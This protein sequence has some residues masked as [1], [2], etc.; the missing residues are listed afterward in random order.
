VKATVREPFKRY[1]ESSVDLWQSGETRL[2]DL[3][4]R[5]RADLLEFAFERY[6]RK[7]GL[8]GTPDSCA[9]MVAA[10]RD[11]GVDE[12]ACLIDFGVAPA[13]ILASLEHLDELRR[14]GALAASR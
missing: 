9:Q 3:P 7:T 2:A 10:A 8:M 11:A 6:Y 12:I 13:E 1:L 4:A 5:K 14:R